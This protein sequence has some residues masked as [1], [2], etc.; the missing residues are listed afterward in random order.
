MSSFEKILEQ[1][2][3]PDESRNLKKGE[4][5]ELLLDSFKEILPDFEF[6]TYRNSTYYFL[7]TKTVR[8]LELYETL[9]ITFGLKDK[10][11]SCSIGSFLNKTYLLSSTYN[12]GFLA[13]HTDLLAVKSGSGVSK[14]EDSY[15]WQSD[16]KDSD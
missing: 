13:Y 10:N 7:R 11:F 1:Q 12:N 14:L 2:N 5:K 15:Y 8:G 16:K 3:G 4:V 6:T 9:N